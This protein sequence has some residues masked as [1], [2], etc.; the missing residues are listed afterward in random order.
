[1]TRITTF[2]TSALAI[3]AAAIATASLPSTK[4]EAFHR[5]HVIGISIGVPLVGYGAYYGY[6]AYSE[7]GWLRHR[8]VVTGNPYW[9]SR[10]NACRGY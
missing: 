10:Y 4:A 1:M 8:A 7:C 3:A 9:W 2:K 6:R 5:R